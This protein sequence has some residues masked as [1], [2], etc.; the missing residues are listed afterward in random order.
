MLGLSFLKGDKAMSEKR[1]DNRN[2]ILH[3]G[4]YQR[5]DGRYRFRYVDIH[6]NEGNLYSWR[7]D[8]NDPIPKGKKMELSLREKEKQ[9]EQDMFNGLVPGGGGLTVLE[10]VE[11]YVSLKI[12][13]RQSTYAG[14][15]TVIN[16]LKKDDFGKKR[17]DKVKL[18]DAK[19]WL[20]K[21]QRV[22]GKG[23]SSIH[24]IRGVL[25]P[26]FQMA[27]EDDLIRK[28]PFGFEL[29]N[30]IVND[31]VRREA[32]TRKQEREFL[33]FIKEDAHFCKYYDAIF[34]LFNTG[35]RISEFCGLTKSDL[36]FKNK[37]IRVNHQLQRTSQMQYIIEKPKT[38]SGERY[39]PMSDEVMACFKRILKDR[40][41]PKVEPMVDGMTGFLFLDKNDMPMVA[42]H[43]EK[44]FQFIREKYNKLYKEPLPTITPHVCSHTFCTKMA[45]AGMN[46][47]KLKYIMGHSS[48]DITFDTYTH[49]QVDDVREEM[50][51]MVE[52]E[53]EKV[54]QEK[55]V[56]I[57]QLEEE[58][59]NLFNF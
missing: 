46:P 3:E 31:S 27:E 21:L 22:D 8:H 45:K 33:R 51:K 9:L 36:D 38:E 55:V 59:E 57:L 7:L 54:M 17:I 29:V 42:L 13:V 28:N 12:G 52:V 49:L 37:R 4:E 35:L 53:N 39:V 20:I 23:Y 16:L 25:R 18:S 30:V 15:K 56:D 2:R 58:D 26:A 14:Y 24:T 43:W 19:A 47:A 34:I 10:L 41:N 32:V 11:K 48:M 40:V 5:A 44:Y 1:R 6:G 50:L